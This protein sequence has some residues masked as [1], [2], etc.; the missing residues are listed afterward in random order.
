[1]MVQAITVCALIPSVPQLRVQLRQLRTEAGLSLDEA[2]AHLERSRAT[3]GHWE[4]GRSRVSA[5]D[6]DALLELYNAPE[7][8]VEQLQHLRRESGQRGWWHSYKL[9]SYLA[10]FVGFEAEA[11]EI[12]HF[13]LGLVP[14]LL[15]T[16]YYARAVHE[17]GRLKL[18]ESELQSWVDVRLKRQ[19]R[20][21]DGGGLTLHAV[22]AEEAIPRVV[23]SRAVMAEQLRHLAAVAKRPSV[24]LQV[25]PFEAGAHA[26]SV[27]PINHSAVRGCFAR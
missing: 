5:K 20:L 8:L 3:V 21:N 27:G 19:E 11:S 18:S 1:M 23:R 4:R 22:V 13:E 24:N 14:G 26:G 12:F 25:L 9:P 6:L 15:Q 10:P 16:E 7:E 17:V 2:A